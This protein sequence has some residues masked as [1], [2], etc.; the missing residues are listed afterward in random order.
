MS[1]ASASRVFVARL[2]QESLVGAF[3]AAGG[4]GAAAGPAVDPV[5]AGVAAQGIVEG[6]AGDGIIARPAVD[7]HGGR[8]RAGGQHIASASHNQ[9]PLDAAG[10]EIER[11]ALGPLGIDGVESGTAII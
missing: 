10:A 3:A 1:A 7:L 2:R 6:R 11:D 4:D 9:D 5:A 8:R